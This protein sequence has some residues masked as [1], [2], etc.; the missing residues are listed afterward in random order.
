MPQTFRS[1]F[2]WFLLVAGLTSCNFSTKSRCDIFETAFWLLY[3]CR[4]I[5]ARY[6][7]PPDTTER[8]T[9]NKSA[10]LYTTDQLRHA[11][12]TFYTLIVVLRNSWCPICLNRLGS[13]PLEHLF[14]KARLK[15]RNV[16]IIK[17]FL[18]AIGLDLLTAETNHFLGS[19]KFRSGEMLS[20][21]IVSHGRH[22]MTW[23]SQS[24]QL[25]L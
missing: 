24:N 22:L 18:S 20:E 4:I 25:P 1:F 10:S 15:C 7:H 23:Y 21:L 2:P 16:N 8:I 17:R 11:L 9:P 19:S 12:S 14:G 6:P 3:F 5:L 13:N